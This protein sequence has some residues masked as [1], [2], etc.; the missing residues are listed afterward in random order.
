MGKTVYLKVEEMSLAL[1][2]QDLSKEELIMEIYKRVGSDERTIKRV[3]EVLGK[4]K[5][6][7]QKDDRFKFK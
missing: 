6:V 1:K 2:G 7:R 5:F 4:F 3:L